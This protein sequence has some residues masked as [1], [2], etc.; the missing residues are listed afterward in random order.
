VLVPEPDEVTDPGVLVSVHVPVDGSPLRTTPPVATAQVGWVIV[1]TEGADG[2]ALTV[3]VYVAIAAEQGAPSGLLVVTVMV[4]I[5][6][7]SPAAGV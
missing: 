5:L 3:R 2:V 6:P 1:P 7:A 4:T